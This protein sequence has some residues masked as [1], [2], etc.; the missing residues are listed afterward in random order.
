MYAWLEGLGLA[1]S[2]DRDPCAT[3]L[4]SYVAGALVVILV[5]LHGRLWRGPGVGLFAAVLV[6]FNRGLLVQMQQATPLT[7][8]LAG[9]MT[10]LYAYAG[11]LRFT[12]ESAS[13]APSA[14]VSSGRAARRWAQVLGSPR[15]WMLL[16]GL[17][18]GLTLM[19]VGP[20]AMVVVPLIWLHQVY[21]GASA[22]T[23]AGSAVVG[24]VRPRPRWWRGLIGG[25]AP[26][27]HA[28]WPRA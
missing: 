17:A 9:I 25:D 22:G 14:S 6:G 2:V 4:P 24:V 7:L 13:L 10:A 8:G 11:H 3:V 28:V 16:G 5:Y 18:L 1:L 19:A 26:D 12:G 27:A 21:L 15:F 23:G 20:F